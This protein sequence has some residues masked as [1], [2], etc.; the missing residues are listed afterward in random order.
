MMLKILKLESRVRLGELGGTVS[1]VL[2][3]YSQSGI[4]EDAILQSVIDELSAINTSF[5]VAMTQSRMLSE[6]ENYDDMRDS[7]IRGIYYY[8]HGCTHLPVETTSSAAKRLLA[9]FKKYGLGVSK[10]SYTEESGQLNSLLGDLKNTDNAADITAV[11]NLKEMVEKLEQT[12]KDFQRMH[13]KYL[14]Q[15]SQV[16]NKQTASVLKYDLMGVL[17]DKLVVYLRSQIIFNQDTHL[18]FAREVALIINKINGNI[19]E[20]SKASKKKN[21][22]NRA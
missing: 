10:L 6:L 3:A 15:L 14:S 18:A 16:Q 21:H 11:P 9:E 17:N 19:R 2:E 5:T 13:S 8:L 1:H 7:V 12:Q 22:E 20:R 4:T